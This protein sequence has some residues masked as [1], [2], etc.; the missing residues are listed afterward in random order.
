M[1]WNINF[2]IP[3]FVRFHHGRHFF[4]ISRT[5]PVGKVFPCQLL[6]LKNASWRQKH[7]SPGIL[8][9]VIKSAY[10][11]VSW[12][13]VSLTEFVWSDVHKWENKI[14]LECAKT[15]KKYTY[16]EA[17]DAT[18][19]FSGALRKSIGEKKD[20]R[21]VMAL[22]LQ[23]CPE[24]APAFL[25]ASHAGMI[26]T[27]VNPS[28]TAEEMSRQMK[29][30][31][32]THITTDIHN[33]RIVSEAVRKLANV[34]EHIK[35]IVTG[36][37]I[38]DGAVSFQEMV[39]NGKFDDA[40]TPED[41]SIEDTVVLPYSSGTTGL[42]KGA[43]LSHKNLIANS[44]QGSH[45]DITLLKPTTDQHQERVLAVIPF[46]HIYGMVVVLL[47]KLAVGAKIITLPRF[48]PKSF[49]DGLVDH[50][51]SLLYL[52]PPLL[53]FLT[54]HPEVNGKTL[55]HLETIM[56]G[57][58]P[59]GAKDVERFTNKVDKQ[60]T[61]LQGYGMTESSPMVCH[62]TLH[63]KLPRN[64][65]SVGH[66][67]PNTIVKFIDLQNGECVGPMK[68]GELCVKGPQ[69]MRGYLNNPEATKQI[70]DKDGWLHSGDIGYYDEAQQIY[71]VDRL[72]ELIKVKGFQVAPVELE[73]ILRTHPAVEN[74]GVVGVPHHRSG[75][76]PRAF[77]VLKKNLG[78]SADASE[79]SLKKWVAER[80]APYKRLDEGGVVIVDALPIS[81]SGKILRRQLRDAVG[82]AVSGSGAAGAGPGAWGDS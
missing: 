82:A 57:A 13:N 71:I 33:Y 26:V 31:G 39:K 22:I 53:L 43:M 45:K 23:N 51:V 38:P 47:S 55:K 4:S 40:K 42:P 35:I 1:T 72:K 59:L 7:T 9:H 56:S 16:A 62:Q 69:V 61:V 65:A 81:T 2:A 28:Y 80:V 29:D 30:C 20:K 50:K 73:E 77:V 60:V 48:E 21:Y 19:R 49:I 70:I 3:S 12:P 36:S 54:S 15:G 67:L 76:V 44:A 41:F 68:R 10:P 5:F 25:G 37:Q 8:Q 11:D 52:V 32:A 79:S 27:T 18:Y 58:A 74:A 63:S 24:Y 66:P 17:K 78:S 75:E 46:F 14:A 6:S 34:K 64:F